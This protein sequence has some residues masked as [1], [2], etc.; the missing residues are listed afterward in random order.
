MVT[1]GAVVIHSFPDGA[2]LVGNPAVN[3]SKA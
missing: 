2:V 3:K 1:V